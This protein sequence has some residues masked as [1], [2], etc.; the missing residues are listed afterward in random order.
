M[1]CA[2]ALCAAVSCAAGR[3]ACASCVGASCAA[4]S[5]APRCGELRCGELRL[6]E[7]R[8]CEPRC[9]EVRPCELHWRGALRCGDHRRRRQTG[10]RQ[11]QPQGGASRRQAGRGQAHAQVQGATPLAQ[12][13]RRQDQV[14]VH[15]AAP[16]ARAAPHVKSSRVHSKLRCPECMFSHRT[17]A[18]ALIA[19]TAPVHG[20]CVDWSN[21]ICQ[22]CT[23]KGY[24]Q[25]ST[26]FHFASSTRHPSRNVGLV[27]VSLATPRCAD[28]A[29]KH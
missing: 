9:G 15:V 27:A 4:A 28:D 14:Q 20:L 3:C 5:C 10:R 18:V 24:A 17:G 29:R 16:R 26:S 8:L 1:R 23:D 21:A 19:H 13:G 12:S 7:R 6:C 2:G 11:A 25:S 22:L